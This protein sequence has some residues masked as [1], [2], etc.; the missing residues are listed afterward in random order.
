[1]TVAREEIF[2]PVLAMI[3]YTDVDNAIDIANDS[4]YGLAGYIQ[5]KD[6][7]LIADVAAQLRV[8]QVN[9]NQPAPDPMAPFGGYKA[10]G[11]DREWGDHAFEGFLETKA[12][13][14]HPPVGLGHA[15]DERV[16]ETV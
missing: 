10:S 4:P 14:G 13:L 7:A 11:N 15:L 8:G 12:L 9:I 2:G 6:S 3:A 16:G 5:G 1:M